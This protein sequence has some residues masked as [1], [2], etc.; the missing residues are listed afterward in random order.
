LEAKKDEFANIQ[1]EVEERTKKND[2]LNEDYE[3]LKKE[4]EHYKMTCE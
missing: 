4:Y 2:E 3:K 1:K